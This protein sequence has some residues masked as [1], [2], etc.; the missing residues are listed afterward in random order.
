MCCTLERD[1][2][3]TDLPWAMLDIT[4]HDNHYKAKAS[5][6]LTQSD[7]RNN[8][9]A[10][11]EAVGKGTSQVKTETMLVNTTNIVFKEF[12]DINLTK[13]TQ[14]QGHVLYKYSRLLKSIH[15]AANYG[16]V[17]KMICM[18]LSYIFE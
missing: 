14:R 6:E 10:T 8:T 3:T 11:C 17:G 2:N 4:E 16:K 1:Q 12:P 15:E 18:Q 13:I 7:T 9:T 5:R